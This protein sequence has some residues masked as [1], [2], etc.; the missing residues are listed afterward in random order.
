MKKYRIIE[1]RINGELVYT[2]QR[3]WW[4]RWWTYRVFLFIPICFDSLE[5]A[6]SFVR[7][8]EPYR[9]VVKEISF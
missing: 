2:V 9:R 7:N 1:E 3:H 8:E 5:S 6:E 4:N